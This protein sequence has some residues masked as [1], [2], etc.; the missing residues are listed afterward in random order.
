MFE[1]TGI[2][3][4]FTMPDVYK[5]GKKDEDIKHFQEEALEAAR[6]ATAPAEPLA[7][8]RQLP[9]SFVVANNNQH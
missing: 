6:P 5:Y 1:P 9:I 8:P 4:M 2:V 3:K 7:K